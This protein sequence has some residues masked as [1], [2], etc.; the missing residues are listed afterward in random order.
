MRGQERWDQARQ[1][2]DTDPAIMRGLTQPRFSRRDMLKYG[3]AGVLGLSALL[4]LSAPT[5]NVVR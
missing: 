3:G 5:F 2:H 1:A 4:V